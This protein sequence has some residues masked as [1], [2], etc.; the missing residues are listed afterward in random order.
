MSERSVSCVSSHDGI[1]MEER[2]KIP[3]WRKERGRGKEGNEIFLVMLRSVIE[4]TSKRHGVEMLMLAVFVVAFSTS[5]FEWTDGPVKFNTI[6]I[7]Q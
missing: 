4:R 7:G 2:L 5:S 3:K 1:E 6:T